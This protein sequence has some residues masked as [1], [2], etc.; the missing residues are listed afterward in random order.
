[1]SLVRKYSNAQ[2]L[3]GF[4]L[5][6]SATCHPCPLNV[7]GLGDYGASTRKAVKP[8]SKPF[9]HGDGREGSD[10]RFRVHGVVNQEANQF[11]AGV[12]RRSLVVTR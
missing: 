5:T 9:H 8:V 2:F 6:C 10:W 11:E 4:R 1:M 3:M 7:S 12:G